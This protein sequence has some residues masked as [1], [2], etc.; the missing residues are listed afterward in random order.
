MFSVKQILLAILVSLIGVAC[1][2]S[3]PSD[4]ARIHAQKSSE[5]VAW[6]NWEQLPED[7]KDRDP[8]FLEATCNELVARREVNFLL[9]SLN[10]SNNEEVRKLLVSSVLYHIDDRRIYD[11]FT[12][13][14]NDKEDE[15]SYYVANYLAKQGN[16]AALA[17][18]NN[19]YFQYP[20]SS[21]QWSYTVELFGK[22]KFMPA[23]TNLVE[24]LNAAFLNLSAAACNALQE[25]FPDSPRH[26][27][28]PT[29][30]RNY[31]IK[32]LNEAPNKSDAA[33]PAMAPWQQSTDHWRGVADPGR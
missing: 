13:R 12:Q 30:A 24:S 29:D 33:N 3:Q 8:F 2:T 22:Y 7:L 11:A 23:T 32:R 17:T 18:L 10:T 27:A 28:G 1:R 25:I 6:L 21:W 4:A 9:A 16:T 20:V 15:E 26:F 14:L 31:Y 19:H 5:L